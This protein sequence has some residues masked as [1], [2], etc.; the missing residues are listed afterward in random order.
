MHACIATDFTQSNI[1]HSIFNY[2][3]IKLY[4]K[5]SN[6]HCKKFFVVYKIFN[7]T[8]KLEKKFFMAKAG[9]IIEKAPHDN[10]MVIAVS[11]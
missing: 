6:F 2:K 5:H 4:S 1:Q 10:P 9:I 8:L 7:V 11:L 3:H